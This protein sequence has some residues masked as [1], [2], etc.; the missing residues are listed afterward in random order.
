MGTKR[1]ASL[2]AEL[3]DKLFANYSPKPGGVTPSTATTARM[4]VPATTSIT[5]LRRSVGARLRCAFLP[6]S[7]VCYF[8]TAG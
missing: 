3:F 5:T 2:F 7:A 4:T 6:V 8:R 1:A